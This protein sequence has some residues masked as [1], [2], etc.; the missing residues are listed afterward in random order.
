MFIRGEVVCVCQVVEGLYCFMNGCSIF[1]GIGLRQLYSGVIGFLFLLIWIKL[2][3]QVEKLRWWMLKWGLVS[4][5]VKVF[6]I[7][8]VRCCRL[9]Q[10][11]LLLFLVFLKWEQMWWIFWNGE[12]KRKNFLL[13]LLMLKIVVMFIVVG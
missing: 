7:Y 10:V 12:L 9:L 4:V 13:V 11:F 5:F 1:F 6:F 2:V 3:L 8:L